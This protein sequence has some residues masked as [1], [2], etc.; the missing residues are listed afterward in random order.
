MLAIGIYLAY[1]LFERELIKREI[2]P[3][4]AYKI[5]LIAIPAGIIGSKVFHIMDHTGEFLADPVGVIFSGAGLSAYGGMLFAL[6][7]SY[8][9]I[10]RSKQPALKILDIA[11]PSMAIGYGFG[12]IGCHIAGDG[13]YGLET[14]GLLSLA[15]PNGIVPVSYTVY[16]TPL[17]ESFFSFIVAVVLLQLRKNELSQ[18]TLFFLYLVLNGLPRF[19]VE[20]IRRNP[21]V[22][23]GFTQAQII[24][25]CFILAGGIGLFIIHH[26]K[27]RSA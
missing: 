20:F 9:I 19:F 22:F 8:L 16:P 1:L 12:R 5:L 10:R 6:F 27:F 21:E 2:N 4:L 18:G 23:A 25:L 26:R 14:T 13:C 7:F 24:A 11:S 15:Y 3:D 17:F